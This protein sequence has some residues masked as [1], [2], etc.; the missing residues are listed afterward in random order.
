[1]G[2]FFKLITVCMLMTA[3][4][5]GY[6]SFVTSSSAALAAA[7]TIKIAHTVAENPVHP[8]TVASVSF[9][10]AL[11][12]LSDGTITVDIYPGG[13]LG[14][15]VDIF[16]SLQLGS[17]DSAI[18]STPVIANTTNVLVGVDMPF[19]F[20]GDYQFIYDILNG[21]AGKHLLSRLDEE[22]DGIRSLCFTHQAFRHIW[23]KNEISSLADLR[24]LKFR[25]MQTPVH[26]AIFKALGAS[27]TAISYNDIYS[28][29]QTGT[30]DAFEMD[31]FGAE[32]N[33]F[34]EVCKNM[35]VSAHFNNAPILIFS[36]SVFD[37]FTDEQQGWIVKAADEA[38]K[39]SMQRT[40]EE[41]GSYVKL[42]MEHGVKVK[43][44]DMTEWKAAVQPVIEQYKKDV[45]EVKYLMD[46]IAATE[47]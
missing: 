28:S 4:I 8:Y 34:Y 11:E 5:L 41:E 33:K 13:Q 44:T 18:L 2:K 19:V 24:G 10:E 32:S 26:I 39:I 12:R 3:V 15:D 42:M 45:P 30:I 31:V 20:N 23:T 21:E 36:K 6:G 37:S 29:M 22:V 9:K 38:A 17:I 46:I 14:G 40:V 16:Q 25:C 47:K 27:P 1:M 7:R 43:E 35:L